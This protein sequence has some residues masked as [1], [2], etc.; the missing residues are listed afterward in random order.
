M[1][2][3]LNVTTDHATIT[4]LSVGPMDNNAYVLTCRETGDQLLIDAAND[5]D[6]L[7][8]LVNDLPGQLAAIFTTH[9]HPDHVQALEALATAFPDATTAAGRDDA[10][11]LPVAPTTLVDE[12]DRIQVGNL[13]LD[14]IHLIGH[15]PGSIALAFADTDVD[16]QQP[17][18]HLFTGD[19]L[20][21]GGVGKTWKPEDFVT[22]YRDVSEKLFG[23]YADD[24][25][26]YPGHGAGTTLGVERPSLDEWKQRGW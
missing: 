3:H 24:T 4:A 25:E 19:S 13:T 11:A 21:P 23:R 7:I 22:L 17:R 20:F 1:P 14:A 26:V 5:A 15:T 6:A 16:H 9:Q 10:A 18:T 12:G 8:K 2:P